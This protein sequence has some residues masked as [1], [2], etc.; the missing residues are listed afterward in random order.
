MAAPLAELTHSLALAHTL[1]SYTVR[2]VRRVAGQEEGRNSNGS[3]R[4]SSITPI[5]NMN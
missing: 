3:R 4:T 2:S 5:R 1:W